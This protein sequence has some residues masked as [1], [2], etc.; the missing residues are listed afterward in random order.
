M[1]YRAGD[2]LNI[3]PVMP[4]SL[5]NRILNLFVDY[6]EKTVVRWTTQLSA[7]RRTLRFHLPMGKP[8]TLENV[9]RN[10]LDLKATPTKQF[11]L[12]LATIVENQDHAEELKKT[13]GDI[14]GFK[15]WLRD[16]MPCSLVDIIERYPPKA[17]EIHRLIEILPIIKPRPYSICSSP[18]QD[19]STVQ[20]CVG[21][22]EDSFENGKIYQGVS[23]HYLK[24]LLDENNPS[25]FVFTE[26][27]DASFDVP[28]DDNQSM[29]LISAGTGF[30]PMRSFLQERKARNAKGKNFVFFGCRSETIDW[31]Y[32]DELLEYQKSGLITDMFVGFSRSNNY[33]KAYVQE[34]L[35]EQSD[36]IWNELENGA[37][38]YVCGSGTRVGAGARDALMQI[39]QKQTNKSPVDY[40]SNLGSSGRYQQDVW[41]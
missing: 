16:N 18:K 11:L 29:I 19:S 5:M 33:P 40:I 10:L 25:A 12:N 17:N 36:L 15:F 28:A 8:M 34:K 3:C 37:Y 24:T 35:L 41:G 13:A 14:K 7:S 6:D 32:S 4:K 22:V 9:F 31:L 39:I 30:A 26:P 23:S 20:I 38:V 21:V 2:H 27:A 1:K